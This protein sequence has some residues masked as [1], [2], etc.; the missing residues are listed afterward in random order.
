MTKASSR[1]AFVI[2]VVPWLA[3][4]RPRAPTTAPR[5]WLN[6]YSDAAKVRVRSRYSRM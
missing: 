3:T 6:T 4:R 1:S 5:Y 2:S